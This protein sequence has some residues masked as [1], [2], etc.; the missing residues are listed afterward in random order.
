MTDVFGPQAPIDSRQVVRSFDEQGNAVFAQVDVAEL[1]YKGRWGAIAVSHTENTISVGQK[2]FVI[3]DDDN[4]FRVGDDVLCT[5]LDD[6]SAFMWAEIVSKGSS[7]ALLTV[8]V[9]DISQA[10]NLT[11]SNWELQ[12]V[13]RPKF[14][15][16]K[17][18]STTSV[19]PTAAGPFTLTV[20]AGKFFPVG[21][22]LLMIPLEAREIA[23]VGR[24]EAYSGTSLVVTKNATNATVSTSYTSWAIA[25]LDAPQNKIQ[26]YLI[27]GLRVSEF[28]FSGTD[29][30]VAA[31][32]I[33]D[34]TDIV[35]LVLPS[36]L[37]KQLDAAFVAGTNQGAFI[38]S[39]NLAGTVSSAATAVTG[40]GTTFQT[41]FKAAAAATL[42]DYTA[43]TALSVFSA[44]FN[45]ANPIITSGAV[46]ANVTNVTS[47]TALVTS[48]ALGV[49]GAT[50]KRGGWVSTGTYGIVL[51]RK[52]SDGS[53]DVGAT[54]FTGSGE[55]DLPSGYTYYRVLA[56][57]IATGG[58]SLVITQPLYESNAPLAKEVFVDA[59]LFLAGNDVQE[60][61][62]EA[63][64]AISNHEDRLV[65]IETTT[66]GSTYTPSLTAVA[67]VAVLTAQVCQ[68][69]QVGSTVTVSGWLT[70]DPTAA[71]GTATA[72]GISLPVAS[73][74]ANVIQCAGT[75]NAT[76]SGAT[77]E[78]GIV[79]GDTV[80]SRAELRFQA[81]N[82]ASHSYAFHFTYRVV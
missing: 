6:T 11:S 20:T 46:T 15:I 39:A 29:I 51:M 44:G 75:G 60:V 43:Q 49:A 69:S 45:T 23:L 67:N 41:D 59:L 72:V 81:Q 30:Q 42:T 70:V 5:S 4:L 14:G 50:Y 74:F 58:G 63:D 64:G 47:Q 7:P 16:T 10:G 17:D 26:K 79:V 18:I 3:L 48:A 62:T 56:K 34:S 1:S 9:E 24:V 65:D 12:V 21:G 22:K 28:A 27:N 33:R 36:T 82:A 25:L 32:A 71:A 57:V 54:S 76:T 40:T 37:V 61:L 55:P 53:V 73:A 80:N 38:Q 35:D 77:N 19:D 13:A 78:A 31:G 68:Y 8:H 66:D 52:D 2:S